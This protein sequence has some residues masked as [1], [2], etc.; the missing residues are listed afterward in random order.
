MQDAPP[1]I[2]A[3]RGTVTAQLLLKM[4]HD[5]KLPRKW[6]ALDPKARVGAPRVSSYATADCVQT[7]A[8]SIAL[9]RALATLLASRPSAQTCRSQGVLATPEVQFLIPAYTVLQDSLEHVPLY[10]HAKEVHLSDGTLEA[11][12]LTFLTF[13]GTACSWAH[14]SAHK[15]DPARQ[16]LVSSPEQPGA[17]VKR[18][19]LL[20]GYRACNTALA[21]CETLPASTDLSRGC[22]SCLLCISSCR[23]QAVHP[24]EP[25]QHRLWCLLAAYNGPYALLGCQFMP[26]VGAHDA[27]WERLTIRLA[28][29][30]FGLQVRCCLP[31]ELYD[32]RTHLWVTSWPLPEATYQSSGLV[33]R[34]YQPVQL[35]ILMRRGCG[36]ML[37]GQET[38]RGCQQSKSSWRTG[39][40]LRM[41]PS[42]AMAPTPRS[43]LCAPDRH[44][45]GREAPFDPHTCLGAA[46]SAS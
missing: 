38:A 36:T 34:P 46:G 13:Y 32:V 33:V 16:L 14:E 40:P 44:Q 2:L 21:S 31:V 26:K 8:H 43:D 7:S 22:T 23:A 41:L 12:E 20:C 1:L 10:V 19:Y 42:M 17:A 6:L 39:A 45:Q 29:P 28:A 30:H 15:R 35:Q 3:P 5:C 11:L 18:H 24:P 9:N 25:S 4:Q 37:T 27:D